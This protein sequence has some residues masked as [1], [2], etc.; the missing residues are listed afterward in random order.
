[1]K[2][3]IDEYMYSWVLPIGSISEVSSRGRTNQ[4][5]K[6]LRSLKKSCNL[7]GSKALKNN[8]FKIIT[9]N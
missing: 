7:L 5:D 3:I 2:V 1:M 9:K 4:T 6:M 8:D